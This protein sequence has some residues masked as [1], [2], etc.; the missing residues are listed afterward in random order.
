MRQPENNDYF[1]L[2]EYRNRIARL[3]EAMAASGMDAVLLS[4]E[5]SVTHFSGL[6]DGYWICT[7][8]DDAQLVLIAADPSTE[9]VLLIPNHLLQVAY[10]SCISDVRSWSQFTGGNS[11]GS[12]ETI[13]DA[14]ADLGV[15][16]GRIGAEIGPHDRP[17]MSIPFVEELK[18]AIPKTLWED[19]TPTLNQMLKIKSPLE[20][21][22]VRFACKV[23]CQA[24]QV[25][26]DAVKEGMS[27]KELAQII[28]LEMARQSP[29]VC[30]NRP[31]FHFIYATG[32]GTTAFDSIPTSYRFQE[33]DAVY[34]DIGFKYQGYTAD[35]I[36][37]AV[38]G[39]PS[40]E[41]ESYY[42][43]ARDANMAA[44]RAVTPGIKGA[45]LYNLW[46]EEVRRLGFGHSMDVLD[47]HDFDFLGHGLGIT[48]HELP[49]I[50]SKCRDELEARMVVAIEGNVLDALPWTETKY[51]LKNE[52]D[53]LVTEDGYEWLTPLAND[54]YVIER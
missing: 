32:R 36:R 44:V 24:M 20:I 45:D 21:E 13:T 18:S 23:T 50:N 26:L 6:L 5:P 49:L 3:R 34:I 48:T 7:M 51:A 1:P 4:T 16:T 28:A 22:K 37:C 41:M 33:G 14:F 12:V 35:M 19:C 9:P 42:N 10:T 40:K 2:S 30:V 52:E 17:G 27:E 46:A 39:P 8:R 11:K 43:A 38:I 47:R 15:D 25:G 31:W 53:V 54:L 29:D